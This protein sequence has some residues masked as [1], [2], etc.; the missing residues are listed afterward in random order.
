MEQVE[1]IAGRILTLRG[2]RVVLDADLAT[3]YGVSTKR[4]NQQVRRNQDRFPRDFVF[5][6]NE[7]E[8]RQ[9]VAMCDHLARLRFSPSLPHAFTEHGAL[10]VASVLNTQRAV[11]VGL[12]VVRAFVQMREALPANREVVRRLDQLERKVG[13][14]D[15]AISEILA[16]IR[17]LAAPPDPPP[18]RR[19]GFVQG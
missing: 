18:K 11:E 14:H 16:A 1:S 13:T 7:L 10:M 17:A 15:R 19:I 12:Y 2:L 4:L 6:L 9:V 3:L 5:Q 8:K